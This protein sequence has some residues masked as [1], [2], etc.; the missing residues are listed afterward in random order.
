MTVQK[1]GPLVLL[2][3]TVLCAL[4][5]AA[6]VV[7]V[8]PS[9]FA[10]EEEDD[11]TNTQVAVPLTDQDQA[12]ANLGAN[13]A[14]NVDTEEIIEEAQSTTP[15]PSEEASELT[16]PVP[17]FKLSKGE[18][19]AEPTITATCDPSSVAD[20]P[21]QRSDSTCQ[22]IGPAFVITREVCD[23]IEG[24]TFNL[25]VFPPQPPMPP[26]PPPPPLPPLGVCTFPATETISCP[27]DVTPTEEGECITKPGRGND[28][29]T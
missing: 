22:V 28:P 13:L 10:Q 21:V 17:G 19:T 24:G 3:F 18:C 29:R 1:T 2:M 6:V 4:P 7:G 9:A 25:I 12:A 16:C 14:A 20:I 15:T 8:I 23:E 27:G 26:L 11:D 5:A